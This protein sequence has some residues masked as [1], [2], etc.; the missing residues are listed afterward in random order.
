[1]RGVRTHASRNG[2]VRL[3][4][5]RRGGCARGRGTTR[6]LRRRTRLEK[7]VQAVRAGWLG[8]IG[9]GIRIVEARVAGGWIGGLGSATTKAL[10]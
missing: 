3:I 9:G 4:Q 2:V 5:V 7:Y 1:M 6:L 10:V 8:G